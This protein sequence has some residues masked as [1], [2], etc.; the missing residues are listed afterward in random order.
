MKK[1]NINGIEYYR[2][3]NHMSLVELSAASGVTYSLVMKLTKEILYTTSLDIYDRISKALGVTVDDLLIEYSSDDLAAGDRPV[4]R[5]KDSRCNCIDIY[6]WAENL[7]LEELAR[8][9]GVSSRERA[10]QVCNMPIPSRKNLLR[11]AEYE[12]IS[13]E[14][15]ER[16]YAVA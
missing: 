8:R 3:K 1:Y 15:F 16:R 5:R 6:R 11:L 14:E 10:R 7:P 9:M 4:S 12:D 13:P 2:L